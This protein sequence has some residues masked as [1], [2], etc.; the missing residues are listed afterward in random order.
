M[1]ALSHIGSSCSMHSDIGP[2][3][4]VSAMAGQA[5]SLLGSVAWQFRLDN[6]QIV[7]R[8]L[9][10]STT[11]SHTEA[12]ADMLEIRRAALKRRRVLF[13]CLDDVPLQSKQRT[14]R[15]YERLCKDEHELAAI[16]TVFN[17]GGG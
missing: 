7:H 12:E 8:L 2:G 17:I 14:S 11:K 16:D 10:E 1:V 15:S 4:A 9:L 6:E 3:F 5:V 13:E